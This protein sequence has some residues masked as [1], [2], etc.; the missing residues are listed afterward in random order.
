MRRGD[1]PRHA[2]TLRWRTSHPRPAAGFQAGR[3]RVRRRCGSGRAGFRDRAG[4]AEAARAGRDLVGLGSYLVNAVG[5][6]NDCHTNPPF[7]TGGNPFWG[8]PT[9]INRRG[10]LAGGTAFGPIISRNIT[11]DAKRL[12][13]GLTL[14]QFVRAVRSGEDADNPGRLLQ[15]MPWPIFANMNSRNLQAIFEYLRAIA[16][17]GD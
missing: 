10:Y 1:S 2:L 13:G 4:A 7:A 6:C 16:A 9:R 3:R 8:E 17:I 5:G 15:V 11:P 12:P 14:R